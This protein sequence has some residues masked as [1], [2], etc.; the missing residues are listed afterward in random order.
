MPP[1]LQKA[2]REDQNEPSEQPAPLQDRPIINEEEAAELDS[3]TGTLAGTQSVHEHAE[4]N[5]ESDLCTR[6]LQAEVKNNRTR[7]VMSFIKS[8]EDKIKMRPEPK[9][10]E[11]ED[12]REETQC[13]SVQGNGTVKL[14]LKPLWSLADQR[15]SRSTKHS[16]AEKLNLES[17]A[18]GVVHGQTTNFRKETNAACSSRGQPERQ[19]LAAQEKL[20]LQ[21]KRVRFCV[22]SLYI[23]SCTSAAERGNDEAKAD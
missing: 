16:D 15:A 5:P 19:F 10:K 23:Y 11:L 14:R 3:I 20:N 2:E 22:G 13:K 18:S 4:A 8:I 21:S 6:G 17:D 7:S 1:F 12:S 9:A